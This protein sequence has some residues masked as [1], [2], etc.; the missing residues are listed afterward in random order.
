LPFSSGALPLIVVECAS[1]G[2]TWQLMPAPNVVQLRTSTRL[3]QKERLLNR[4]MTKLP[5][6]FKKIA[7]V[8]AD[9]LFENPDWAIQASELLN[10]FAVVQLG[11]RVI[12]LPEANGADGEQGVTWETFAAVYRQD[13]HALLHGDFAYHGH[14]GFGWAVRR[15]ALADGMLYDACIA[16]GGDHVMAHAFCGDWESPCLTRMMGDHSPWHRHAMKWSAEIY[17][18]TRAR[19]GVVPGS[20]FHLWHGDLATRG[21]VRRYQSLHEECFDPET[22]LQIDSGGCWRW[23]SEK[24]R[25][26]RAVSDYMIGRAGEDTLKCGGEDKWKTNRSFSLRDG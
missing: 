19:M 16:G 8:D 18:R 25:L 1:P 26:H 15:T 12:R 9:I 6:Q 17:S 14:T 10:R 5:A 11:D 4:A 23:S 3:W 24:P 22:D 21:H 7:W 20:V 2:E 13:P